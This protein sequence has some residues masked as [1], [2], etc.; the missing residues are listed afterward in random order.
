MK[1]LS[2]SLNLAVTVACAL[3]LVLFFILSVLTP[4]IPYLCIRFSPFPS[5]VAETASRFPLEAMIPGERNNSNYQAFRRRVENNP[6][7]YIEALRRIYRE[8]KSPDR[9]AGVAATVK[10]V[11]LGRN[12]SDLPSYRELMEEIRKSEK[13]AFVLNWVK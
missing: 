8:S 13:D 4:A 7:A 11:L 1:R 5:I 3:L 6:E 10:L 9:R 12:A 2:L